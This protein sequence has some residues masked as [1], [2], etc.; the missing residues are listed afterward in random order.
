[1]TKYN[2]R[3]TEVDN[4]RFDSQKE[5]LAYRQFKTLYKAGE[6]VKLTLQPEFELQ[7]AFEK[8]GKKYR[9]I[10]YRADFAVVWKNG[11]LEIFDVKGFSTREFK[12]KQKLFEYRFKDLKITLL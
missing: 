11:K 6:I 1:M 12:L 2:A 8:N 7:P 10:I 9:A 4:I 3:P 5:A